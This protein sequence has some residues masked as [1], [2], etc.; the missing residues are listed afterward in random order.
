MT[1]RVQRD[2]A[3]LRGARLG[4]DLWD[5][6]EEGPR[7]EPLEDR[8]SPRP[9]VAAFALALFALAIALV[10]ASFRPV[11][12]SPGP[13]GGSNVVPV[14]ARG[15]TIATYLAD[16]HPVFVTH[17]KDGSVVVLDAFSPLREFG[18]RRLVARCTTKP[19][20]VT[21]PHPSTFDATGG[22]SGG[23]SA[24]PGL[25]SYSFIVDARDASGSPSRIT[26]GALG[27]AIPHQHN[28]FGGN[29]D[30]SACGLA[31]G[32]VA[33]V[34]EHAVP[35][36]KVWGSVHALVGSD[37]DGWVAVRGALEVAADGR[38]RLCSSSNGNACSDGAVVR[39]LDGGAL[40]RVLAGGSMYAGEHL[41][42][43]RVDGGDV[44]DLAL[45]DRSSE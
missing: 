18:I 20:F 13:L 22:W 34:V 21:W 37:P 16:G 40:D 17:R 39:G 6:I 4:T 8:R 26:V 36:S 32:S 41:W 33:D 2:L 42:L 9:V 31:A 27:L 7:L 35:A 24:L 12:P 19:E 25:G 3:K 1:D 11:T 43:A 5:R 15:R 28:A 10:W 38:V 30:R 23:V 29:A 44:V 45:A 14:P